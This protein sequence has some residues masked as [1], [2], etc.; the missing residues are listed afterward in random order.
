M[1]EHEYF[2]ST[3]NMEVPYLMVDNFLELA[4]SIQS[5]KFFLGNASSCFQLAEALKVPRLLEICPMIPN[6]IPV[7]EKAYDAYHQVHIEYLFSKL[8]NNS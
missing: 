3:W 7:G 2:C 5:C 4:E 8:Y 6:V 1:E